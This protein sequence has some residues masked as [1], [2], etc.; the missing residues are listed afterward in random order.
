MLPGT[1]P[2]SVMREIHVSTCSEA[3][4]SSVWC[5]EC[6]STAAC[7]ENPIILAIEEQP[8]SGVTF[9]GFEPTY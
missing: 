6:N 9:D 3:L 7:N 4:Y 5:V 8:R 2:K 1:M